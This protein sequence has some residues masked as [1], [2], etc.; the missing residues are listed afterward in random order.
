VRA[1]ET[2]AVLVIAAGCAGGL[3]LRNPHEGEHQLTFHNFGGGSVCAFHVY[4]IA[5]AQ[6]GTNRLAPDAELRSGDSRRLWLVPGDYQV[7][8][9]GCSYETLDVSGYT[10]NVRLIADSNVVL[11][12]EDDAK[13]AE[14]AMRIAH[15][16]ENTFLVLAKVQLIP[17]PT[18]RSAPK[19][20]DSEKPPL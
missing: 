1:L 14:A 15:E 4:P 11:Y 7:R 8:A 13:S 12:R 2:L 6:V 5:Q 20:L 3:T 19:E 18:S 10:T 16:N 17:H 9:T